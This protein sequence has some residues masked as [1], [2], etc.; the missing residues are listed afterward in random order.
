MN[1]QLADKLDSRRKIYQDEIAKL[2]EK[3]TPQKQAMLYAYLHR[4]GHRM[5]GIDL[6][7]EK[8]LREETT[9]RA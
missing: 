8:G 6:A 9:S 5:E 7:I 3:L 4:L 2:A 1:E